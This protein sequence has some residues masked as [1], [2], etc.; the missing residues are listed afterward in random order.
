LRDEG[1]G[2]IVRTSLI[3]GGHLATKR[4]KGSEV[5]L[6]Y[7][8]IINPAYIDSKGNTFAYAF[9]LAA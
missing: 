4:G 9:R 1:A 3:W 2:R 8:Q 5:R 7:S 6:G